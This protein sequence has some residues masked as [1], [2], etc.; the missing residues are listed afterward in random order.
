MS[1]S[2]GQGGGISGNEF[3]GSGAAQSG[4]QNTQINNYWP[5]EPPRGPQRG[6]LFLGGAVLTVL[7]LTGVIWAVA[8][9][10]AHDSSKAAGNGNPASASTTPSPTPTRTSPSPSLNTG[11][12]APSASMPTPTSL[13]LYR[14][15]VRIAERGPQLDSAHPKLVDAFHADVRMTLTGDPPQIG[16]AAASEVPNLALWSGR[17]MPTREQCADKVSTEGVKALPAEKGEVVCL[18][19]QGG[20]AAVLTLTSVTN[21]F[22]TGVEAEATVWSEVSEPSAG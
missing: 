10:G 14:G 18:I 21:K 9:S 7:I 15:P 4:S 20:R 12:P 17:G 1:G 11:A 16:S 6:P 2:G 13:Y 3:H 22:D 19:T 5:G 8:K